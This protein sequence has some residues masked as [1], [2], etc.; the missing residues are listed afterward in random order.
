M[1]RGQTGTLSGVV[2]PSQLMVSQRE[3]SVAPFHMGAGALKHLRE[4][5][6][7]LLQPVL[8]SW[9][10]RTE[11]PTGRKQRG[12]EALGKLAKWLTLCHRPRRG[13]ALKIIRWNKMGVHS[14]GL[15][16][17][18]ISLT[19]LLPHIPRDKR[20]GGLHFGHHA[21]GFRDTIQARLAEAF[22]LRNGAHRVDVL[23]DIPGNEL[24]VATHAALQVDKV[25]GVADGADT[26][27]DLL[28]LFAEALVLVAS[29]FHVLLHLLQARGYF[30]RAARARLCRFASGGVEV[31]L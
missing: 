27:G 30:W 14:V 23:L 31:R 2:E 5:C 3:V 29:G 16:L 22:L 15:S 7:L 9:R 8:R 11:G 25:V 18:Q 4:F 24:A 28:A 26:L 17:R 10:Q 19:H 1:Y 13:H 21:L 20:N 12:A 6:G